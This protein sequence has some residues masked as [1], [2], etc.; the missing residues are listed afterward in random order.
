MHTQG[1][2]KVPYYF[3]FQKYKLM[4]C[5]KYSDTDLFRSTCS[6]LRISE[7]NCYNYHN[8]TSDAATE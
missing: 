2:Q 8:E 5:V 6:D 4:L 7:V 1:Y 3:T